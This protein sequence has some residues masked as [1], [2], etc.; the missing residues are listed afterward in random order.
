MKF[1]HIVDC[2][3]T[4][5]QYAAELSSAHSWPCE[6]IKQI[7]TSYIECS[8]KGKSLPD[9]QLNVSRRL[10]E[11]IKKEEFHTMVESVQMGTFLNV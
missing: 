6:M 8:K 1:K 4:D 2:S 3:R 10:L 9:F 11:D 7:G 5:H